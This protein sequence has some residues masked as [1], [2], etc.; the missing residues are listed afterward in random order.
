MIDAAEV[1]RLGYHPPAD[2]TAVLASP[3]ASPEMVMVYGGKGGASE[4]RGQPVPDGGCL[5]EARRELGVGA[6]ALGG[7]ELNRIAT[8][9][10]TQAQQDPRLADANA[11]WSACMKQSGYAYTDIWRA[12]NDPRWSGPEPSALEL[13]TARADVACKLGTRLPTILLTIETELQTVAIHRH[14][15]ALDRAGT[16]RAE[17]VTRAAAVLARPPA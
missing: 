1:A 5:G 9:S 17:T 14:A 10:F 12:N 16:H 7:P 3:S 15:T 13:A 2:P 11:A 4:L 8:D 6:A